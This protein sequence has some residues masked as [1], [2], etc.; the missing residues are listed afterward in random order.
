MKLVHTVLTKTVIWDVPD[1]YPIT[2]IPEDYGAGKGKI[3]ITCFDGSWSYYWGSMGIHNTIRSFFSKCDPPY[4][5]GKLSPG[6]K[7]TV[8]DEDALEDALKAEIV[9]MRKQRDIGKDEASDLW[10][11]VRF[12]NLEDHQ[13]ICERVFGGEW[14]YCLP[15]K[16]NHEYEHL[17]KIIQ[18]IKQAFELEK[19]VNH[20]SN[21]SRCSVP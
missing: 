9:R 18:T 21:Q 17:V 14:W 10:E 1:M 4:L 12:A 6:M 8:N 16:P 7:S 15:K 19:E 5:I 11:D 20:A 3:T 13:D 2:V